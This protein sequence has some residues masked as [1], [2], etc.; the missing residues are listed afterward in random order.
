MYWLESK[1]N[2]LS[3]WKCHQEMEKP[4]GIGLE[5]TIQADINIFI[6]NLLILK[7]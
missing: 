2:G 3:G 6:Y 5:T 4:Y 1:S 7:Q